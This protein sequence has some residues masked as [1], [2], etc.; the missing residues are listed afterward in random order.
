M[1]LRRCIQHVKDQNYDA[2]Y[3][4]ICDLRLLLDAATLDVTEET[5]GCHLRDDELAIVIG[6]SHQ[7]SGCESADC[8]SDVVKTCATLRFRDACATD[9]SRVRRSLPFMFLNNADLAEDAAK[10]YY[11]EYYRTQRSNEPKLF[12]YWLPDLGS[13]Q[14]PARVFRY[15]RQ[16]PF[17]NFPRL[18]HVCAPNA[19]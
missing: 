3:F 2:P 4:V 16:F 17:R 6:E 10:K 15:L 14:G 5:S 9:G 18:Q 8:S 7:A 19:P 11:R 1:I 12:E 13:N